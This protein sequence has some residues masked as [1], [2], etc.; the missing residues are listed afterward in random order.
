M[1]L[2]ARLAAEDRGPAVLVSH[3]DVIKVVVL[4]LIG[5]SLGRCAHV[6]V[7]PASVTTLD[8]WS[9]G[10]KIVRLNGEARA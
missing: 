7:D 5:A 8:L 2:I 9:G 4:T 6:A 10:G 1:P 3:S